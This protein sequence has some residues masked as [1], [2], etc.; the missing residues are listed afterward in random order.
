[1][2]KSKN[3]TKTKKITIKNHMV[4]QSVKLLWKSMECRN[5]AT[6]RFKLGRNN[7]RERVR[8]ND[9]RPMLVITLPKHHYFMGK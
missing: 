7:F 9:S 3:F 1:M 6:K 5:M 8:T 2:E 4:T